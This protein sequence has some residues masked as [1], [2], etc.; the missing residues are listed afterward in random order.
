MR[1]FR[2][3]GEQRTIVAWPP[4]RSPWDD[5]PIGPDAALQI[6]DVWACVR[7]LA[8]AA[9]SI[10]LITYRRTDTGRQRLSS[11]RLPELLQRPAPA[12]SQ[13]NLVAQAMT[14][15]ALFGNGFLGK[16]RDQD[17]RLEQ[18][19]ML[20]PDRV[21][22]ELKGGQPLYTVTGPKG[23]QSKH[24]PDDIVHIRAL[25][26]DGLIGL[27]PIKQCKLAVS[28]S[29][30]MGEFAEAFVR[31]GGRPSGIISLPAGHSTQQAKDF[32]DKIDAEYKGSQNAHK[33][34]IFSGDVQWTALSVPADDA[35]FCEQRKLST[36]EIARIFRVPVWMIG[37]TTGD[38][39]TYS[40]TEQQAL[41]FV[42]HSLRPWLVLIEQAITN[43]PDLCSTNVYVEFLLDALLRADSKTRADVYALALDPVKGWMSRD[44]VRRLENL[45]PEPARLTL[46][47]QQTNGA[48][49]A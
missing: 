10:P 18:L 23:E 36:A 37:G 31:N 27:S 22:V 47:A 49:I 45:E 2:R 15:L 29:E 20:H 26:S 48:L 3:K 17:G 43:D 5:N 11:G 7:V 4:W 21:T 44:E 24:G 35:Q 39:L 42:T 8:D 30:G 1:V 12:T 40:N 19:G 14:H 13:A 38:S 33:I 32:R 16:F 9:A 6:A 25:S 28:L 34:A 46:P 41:Q